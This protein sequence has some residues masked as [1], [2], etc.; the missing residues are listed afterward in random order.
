MWTPDDAEKALAY[1]RHVRASCPRCGEHH[2]DWHDEAGRELRDPP[3]VVV[4][5]L[6]PSCE[7]IEDAGEEEDYRKHGV[8]PGLKW[9]PDL[10]VPAPPDEGLTPGA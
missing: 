9:S 10:P 3:K 6:C 4:P 7:L 2:A 1:L 5:V 8:R